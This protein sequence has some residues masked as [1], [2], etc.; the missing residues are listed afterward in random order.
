LHECNQDGVQFQS[1]SG[2]P[3]SVRIG[4][5]LERKP[6][7]DVQFHQTSEPRSQDVS[8]DAKLALEL[9]KTCRALR[10]FPLDKQGPPLADLVE[11]RAIEQF[12][13]SKRFRYI[14]D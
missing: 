8:R 14:V 4:A 11:A 10:A 9:V 2:Q 7:D 6:F 13:P 3:V 12:I 5:L 1:L